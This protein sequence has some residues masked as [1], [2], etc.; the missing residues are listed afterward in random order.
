MDRLKRRD[1][2][3]QNLILEKDRPVLWSL[4]ILELWLSHQLDMERRRKRRE[5]EPDGNLN[6]FHNRINYNNKS[7][8]SKWEVWIN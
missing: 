1:M 4:M 5:M 3:N 2:L 7:M 8:R 6:R